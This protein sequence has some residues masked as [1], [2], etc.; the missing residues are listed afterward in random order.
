MG[1]FGYEGW[2]GDDEGYLT[3]A[4]VGLYHCRVPIWGS[5]VG[6]VSAG[7]RRVLDGVRA[8]TLER[9]QSAQARRALV[10]LRDCGISGS[11]VSSM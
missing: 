3:V 2:P 5:S 11:Q 1:G 9:W 10:R 7:V 6:I 4:A 8:R